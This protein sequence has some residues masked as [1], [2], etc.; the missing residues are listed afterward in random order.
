[1]SILIKGAK[2][3]SGCRWCYF[4]EDCKCAL[5]VGCDFDDTNGTHRRKDCP[6]IEL[7]DDAT[8]EPK[9]GKCLQNKARYFFCSECHYGVADVFEG[10]YKNEEQPY[11]F[12]DGKEWNFC[13]NCGA[14]MEEE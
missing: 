9:K 5:I 6:L 13:P 8:I 3:P 12:E 11:V 4:N 7:P 1:M 10:N 14:R 2:P